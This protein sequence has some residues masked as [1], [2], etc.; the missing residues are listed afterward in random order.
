MLNISLILGFLASKE[1]F[2]SVGVR[3][4]QVCLASGKCY[5]DREET[6]DRFLSFLLLPSVTNFKVKSSLELHK[7]TSLRPQFLEYLCCEALER[8]CRL[9]TM[10]RLS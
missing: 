10:E 7:S 1:D 6:S 2:I 3:A 5:Y 8:S 4:V 9:E